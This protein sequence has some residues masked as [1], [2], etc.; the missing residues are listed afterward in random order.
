MTYLLA[1]LI[2]LG[3]ALVCFGFG[4]SLAAVRIYFVERENRDLRYR[5]GKRQFEARHPEWH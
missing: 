5:L 4:Y 3:F 1:A 2:T